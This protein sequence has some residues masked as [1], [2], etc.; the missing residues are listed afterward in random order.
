MWVDECYSA[1]EEECQDE[2]V[3][4]GGNMY[5]VFACDWSVDECLCGWEKMDE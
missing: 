4:V 3:C 1:H 5:C 2:Y